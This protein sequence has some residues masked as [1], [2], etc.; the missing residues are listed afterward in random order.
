MSKPPA[1]FPAR[2]FAVIGAGL[3]G[4]ACARTLA[5]AGHS[6]QLFEKELKVGGRM[7]SRHTTFGTFDHGTQFFTVRDERFAAALETSPSA[8]RRWSA[9]AVRVLDPLG[10]VAEAAQPTPEFHWVGTPAMDVLPKH[11]AQPLADAG[12]LQLGTHVHAIERDALDGDRW[13]LHTRGDDGSV[14]VFPAFDAVLLAMPA[15]QSAAL[16]ER[17]RLAPTFVERMRQVEVAPC[18]TLMLAFP[19]AVQPGLP[20][21][22]PQWN[23]ALSTHHRIAWLARE[24]SKPG[25]GPVERWTVQ[26]SPAWSIEHA[27]DDPQRVEAKLRK[28]FAEITGIRAEPAHAEVKRWR[29][30][31]TVTPLGLSHLWDARMG[32]GACGDWCLGYRLEHA[33]VSGLE[34]ALATLAP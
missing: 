9:S 29:Y 6:V 15:A 19:Q 34:L 10:R 24:S 27:E 31:K 5:Q 28:A 18:W 33:F 23:A 4:I 22:G 2:N 14:H 32:V 12:A 13:Q 8:C 25:R 17:S 20:H 1:A 16:L 3:A 26:A 7:A 21:I 30:A 11:W